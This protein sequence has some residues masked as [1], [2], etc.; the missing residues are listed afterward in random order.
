MHQHVHSINSQFGIDSA[1]A[2]YM[3]IYGNT[4]YNLVFNSA[5]AAYI[6]IYGNT[7]CNA[8]LT[9]NN[10]QTLNSIFTQLIL[11]FDTWQFYCSVYLHLWKKSITIEH[12]QWIRHSLRTASALDGFPICYMTVLLQHKSTFMGTPIA[13][14]PLQWIMHYLQTAH[15]LNR[16][17]ICYTTVL[18]Q[19]ICK[20]TGTNYCN[21]T[22]TVNN[23]PTV[24]STFI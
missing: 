19:H 13:V 16:F 21:G 9:A 1:T 11:N 17:S 14:E 8:I 7:Y 5:T 22:L 6:Y 20:F 15:S 10:A 2:A 23:A 24:N 18:L 3:D 4:F 12:W